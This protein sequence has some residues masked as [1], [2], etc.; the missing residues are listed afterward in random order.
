ML[1][2]LL[3]VAVRGGVLAA[4]LLVLDMPPAADKPVVGAMAPD[5]TI[6]LFDGSKVRL[7]DLRGK[8]VIL[9]LWATWCG[10]CKR[11]MPALDLM[12][13]NAGKHGLQIYGVLVQ[14]PTPRYRLRDLEKVL[15][16]PLARS[17]NK[18]LVPLDGAVPTNYII[19]RKGVIRYARA[20]VL[21]KEEFA[22]LIVPLINERP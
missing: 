9:N 22:E 2:N 4:A 13:V 17:V 5:A 19:D 11:E 16:Y 1:G 12:Q 10:P 18:G 6:V 7:A 14:D 8:V 15:H 20:A 21:D 3:G